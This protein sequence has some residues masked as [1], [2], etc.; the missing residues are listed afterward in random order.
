MTNCPRLRP[1]ANTV[2][3]RAVHSADA[4]GTAAV[5]TSGQRQ[6][7]GLLFDRPPSPWAPLSEW[8][9]LRRSAWRRTRL[10]TRLPPAFA[11]STQPSW[12][13]LQTREASNSEEV[14][15]KGFGEAP[16]PRLPS[17]PS[18]PY[19]DPANVLYRMSQGSRRA[20]RLM[21]GP[22]L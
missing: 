18:A 12:R 15:Q 11:S 16:P 10:C 5:V 3:P 13:H 8:Q 19:A 6:C 9:R 2:S 1:R 20:R 4:A 21:P 17:I 22:N 14:R 7:D